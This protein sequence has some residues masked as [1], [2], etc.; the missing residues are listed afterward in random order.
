VLR[1]RTFVTGAA[2]VLAAG[3]LTGLAPTAVHAAGAARCGDPATRP[4]CDASKDPDAR[5]ALLLAAMTQD[6]EVQLLGGDT[7]GAAPHTGATFAI[8][9]LGLPAVYFSDGPVGPRQGSATA[10]PIPESLAAGF[11][12]TLA[13][14]HGGEIAEE[15]KAKGNDVV[16]APT[17]NILRNPQG[18]RSYETYGEETFL[19]GRTAVAWVQGAQSA[20]VVA[21][22]KH[23]AANNQEGQNGVPPLSAVNGGRMLV[24]ANVDERTL[25]EVY[26]PHFEAAVKQA[27]VGSIMCS[28]N[29]VNGP[30]ACESAHNLQQ[31]LQ[32]DWGFRNLVLSDYGAAHNPVNNLNNGLDFEPSGAGTLDSYTVPGIDAALASG[33]VSKATLDGHVLRILRTFFAF[34]VLDRPAYANDDA[35]IDKAAHAATAQHIAEQGTVLLK[36]AGGLLPLSPGVRSIAVI[37]PYADRFVTGGGS[38]TVTAFAPTT[39]LAGIRARVGPGVSVT[40]ADGSDQAA[41]AAVARAADVAVV[42]VGDV[43]TEG[44]DKDCI[45]LN[46]TS[47]L[48]DSQ[49]VLV[50]QGS[51]CGVQSCPLNG[52]NEDGLVTAVAAANPRT[53]TVLE[54]GGPVL[55]P[56]RDQVPAVLEAWYPGQEG[57]KAIARV[58]FGDVDPGGRLPTTFPASADQLPT[59]GNPQSY[60]GVAEEETYTEGL[61]VGYRWYDAHRLTPAYPFGA[62]L[63]Y[64]SFAYSGLHVAAGVP[65]SQEVATVTATVTNIGTRT[66]T[67]VPQ[68]YPGKPATAALPQP[69]RQLAG[70]QKVS[71]APGQSVAVAFPLVDRSFASWDVSRGTAADPSGGWAISPGCYAV[72]V[73]SSSREL[74]LAGSIGQQASCGTGAPTLATAA[75][76]LASLPL[77]SAPRTTAV[78]VGIAP[79]TQAPVTQAPAARRPSARRRTSSAPPPA[80]RP[81]AHQPA[82]LAQPTRTLAFTGPTP[83]TALTGALA[84]G[85]GATMRR[86]RRTRAASR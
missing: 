16:F 9:R 44:Q 54:T 34:G 45:G 76:S 2:S 58:L 21:D 25:R 43:Q 17:V 68:L 65:G 31:V 86:R 51:S 74:P 3:A 39:V 6:E 26:F 24:N 20:G 38:G 69:L 55:T 12:P 14:A 70:Y 47:D 77:P 66:G 30:F 64:T 60:P 48:A 71:L 22:I 82:A 4:W 52:M 10:M 79:A 59:A 53:V 7:A 5:A 78:R 1:I 29:R 84:L 37:G 41:A 8:P 42:V 40:Y 67:A 83:W 33:A 28:Y 72:T 50:L 80:H 75:P 56:W 61:D 27:D 19:T 13:S 18:G 85:L 36:N 11:D 57:G 23:F 35:Q 81:A 63:S 46:C 32:R 49:S 62:G 73:G 15:A